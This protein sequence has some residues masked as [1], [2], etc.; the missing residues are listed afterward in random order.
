[1][2]SAFPGQVCDEINYIHG[3]NLRYD[4]GQTALENFQTLI[5]TIG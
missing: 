1:M 3:Q 4:L 5:H 2:S